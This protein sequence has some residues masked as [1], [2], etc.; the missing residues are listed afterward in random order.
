MIRVILLLGKFLEEW[1]R[2]NS[3]IFWS[4]IILLAI[5]FSSCDQIQFK[6]IKTPTIVEKNTTLVYKQKPIE[7]ILKDSNIFLMEESLM[8]RGGTQMSEKNSNFEIPPDLLKRFFPDWKERVEYQ[9]D[10]T[11][12]CKSAHKK[13][14]EAQR[15]RL[16]PSMYTS[17]LDQN[18]KDALDY[19]SGNGFYAYHQNPKVKPNIFDTRRSFL[20]KMQNRQMREKFLSSYHRYHHK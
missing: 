9:I 17:L 18:E 3:K 20:V 7:E 13:L 14:K 4:G 6:T 16:A 1:E 19:F 8:C 15:L 12:A 2:E 11:K 10:R 5:T